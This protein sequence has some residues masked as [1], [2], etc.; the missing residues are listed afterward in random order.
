MTK[1][2]M[3]QYVQLRKELENMPGYHVILENHRLT[4]SIYIFD[5]NYEELA[6]LLNFMEHDQRAE[7]LLSLHGHKQLYSIDI[8]LLRRLH[9]FVAGAKSLIDHTRRIYNKYYLKSNSFPEYKKTI[10][11]YFAN[12]PL[13][14]FIQD[15]REYCQHYRAPALIYVTHY[16]N[17]TNEEIR[18]V[19][20]QLV[21]LTSFNEWNAT[22]R[23]YL[24]E[25]KDNIPI[26]KPVQEY[27]EKVIRF[28]E[29]FQ[30]KQHAIHASDIKNYKAKETEMT[31]IQLEVQIKMIISNID[32]MPIDSTSRD[33][34]SPIPYLPLK[35]YMQTGYQYPVTYY[36]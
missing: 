33:I 35:L 32:S 25:Y 27:R 3:E 21:D 4:N 5:K 18:E 17:G 8:E 1:D 19:A 28:Y 16:I 11:E 12:D 14:Q 9:N 24:Q 20:L 6:E 31:L 36:Q 2:K 30:H 10:Q 29:W 13:S 34:D 23:Q 22:A 7:E 26:F 15:L